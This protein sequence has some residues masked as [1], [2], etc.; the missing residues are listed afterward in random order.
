MTS[1]FKYIDKKIIFGC[2]FKISVAYLFLEY[3]LKVFTPNIQIATEIR[4]TQ[5]SLKVE[6][7]N[8]HR[9]VRVVNDC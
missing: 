9:S 7:G 2:G 3:P 1:H 8:E 4:F 5:P 6:V